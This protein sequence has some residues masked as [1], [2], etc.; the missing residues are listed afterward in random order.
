MYDVIIV[1]GGPS[2]LSCAIEAKKE[3]LRYLVIEKGGIADAIRRFPVNM[4]FFSTPELL[5][6]GGMPFTTTHVR[7]SRIEAL[8]YYRNVVDHFDLDI[9]LHTKVEAI[10]KRDGLF[11]VHVFGDEQLEARNVIV[12]TGYFDFTNR[13][14]IPGED[15]PHV[16][17]YYDEPY[18]YA[19]TDV[20]LV[21]GRNSSVE[22][23]LELWRHGA[24]VT[25]VHRREGLGDSVK[26]W[27]RPDIEN[28]IK[29]EGGITAR[30]DTVLKAIEPKR[31]LLRDVKTGEEE[32]VKADFVFP[33]IGYRPDEE[34]LRQSGIALDEQLIPDYEPH[35]FETN[36]PG[37]YVAG[38]VVCGCETWNIFIENG[39]AHAMPIIA[40]I[41]RTRGKR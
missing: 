37:L 1:G 2:G 4:T 9:R 14:G 32:W 25:L 17:H 11:E 40:D 34:L 22:A 6:L 33:L 10:K 21:G 41:V 36:I 5:T 15:L 30:F 16:S 23:A 31:C 29:Q 8:Q 19:H 28:R 39:R 3:K 24:R 13:L 35:S 12:A 26:Y 18:A 7:P 27:V 38:S 20:L